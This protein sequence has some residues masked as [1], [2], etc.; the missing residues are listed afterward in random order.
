M[1]RTFVAEW[2]EGLFASPRS[3][4]AGRPSSAESASVSLRPRKRFPP[5]TKKDPRRGGD[6]FL[7]RGDALP[8][9]EITRGADRISGTGHAGVEPTSPRSWVQSPRS[10]PTGARDGTQR[11]G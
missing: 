10:D 4:R 2:R 9:R 6:P 1:N 8:T 5:G 11:T 3:V 7:D